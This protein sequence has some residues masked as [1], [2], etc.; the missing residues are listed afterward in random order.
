[1]YK[2]MLQLDYVV[3]MVLV[4]FY[5]YGLYLHPVVS[6]QLTPLDQIVP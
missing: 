6:K 1:M 5:F 2:E 3:W 4:F